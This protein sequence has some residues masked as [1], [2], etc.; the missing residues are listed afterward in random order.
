MLVYEMY[1]F[2]RSLAL[3]LNIGFRLW[4][5][6]YSFNYCISMGFDQLLPELSAVKLMFRWISSI[7]SASQS[8]L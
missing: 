7:F 5:T 4:V 2:N 1:F 6:G 3:A 8:P